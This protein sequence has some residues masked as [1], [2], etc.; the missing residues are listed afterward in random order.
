MKITK[1]YLRQVIQEELSAVMEGVVVDFGEYREKAKKKRGADQEASDQHRHDQHKDLL[2]RFLE[3]PGGEDY[4][5]GADRGE[6]EGERI[7]KSFLNDKEKVQLDWKLL[8]V[9][10]AWDAREGEE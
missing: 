6:E 7:L 1:T 10:E 5:L 8:N 3:A 2:R 4:L 9:I